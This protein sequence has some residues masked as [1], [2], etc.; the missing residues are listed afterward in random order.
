MSQNAWSS[1]SGWALV[2]LLMFATL[3]CSPAHGQS[4]DRSSESKQDNAPSALAQ[5]VRPKLEAALRSVADG[6]D[7]AAAKATI[8]QLFD[9]VA[10][11][12]GDDELELFRDAAAAVRLGNLLGFIDESERADFMGF[13]LDHMALARALVFL[14]RQDANEKR[15]AIEVIQRLRQKHA[16][17]MD[18]FANLAAAIAV[19]HDKPLT[20]RI[21]ENKTT[22]PDPVSLYEYYVGNADRMV[23]PV[24]NLPAELLVYVVDSTASIDEMRWALNKYRGTRNVGQ[25]FFTIEY[26]YDHFRKGDPKKVTQAGFN[27]PN[28][29]KYGGV[30][31]DQAYFA[32]AVG[33]AIGVP[34]TYT[35][36][37]SAEVSHAWVGFLESDKRAAWWNFNSGRYEAY[38]GVSGYVSDPQGGGRL[39]DSTVA[40]LA[41]YATAP[42]LDRYASIAMTDVVSRLLGVELGTNIPLQIAETEQKPLRGANKDD[43]LALLEAALRTCPGYADAWFVVR[44]Q[45]QRGALTLEEKKK[46]ATVLHRLCGERYPDFYLAVVAP[47]IETVDDVDEQNTLWNAAFRTFQR[48]FDLAASVR[49]RQATMW[50]NAGERNKAGMCCEDV[51]K[52]YA[53]AGPFVLDALKVATD[54][55]KEMN[56]QNRIPALYEK[57]WTLTKKPKDMAAEFST[58]SN[59][60]RVGLLYAETLTAVGRTADAGNVRSAIGAR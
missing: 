19:V 29:L 57:A 49:M 38:Q 39:P 28:I 40:L 44:K 9:E 15:G 41:A 12:A 23:F 59:W 2:A 8:S 13:M 31:A 60:Y 46:W 27:L 25:L 51:I 30:C 11:R 32:C 24:R 4:R 17:S 56:Q 20:R 6:G 42:E 22:A 3:L 58:Q 33:K 45:A 16:N 54:L 5:E 1:R 14:V 10:A 50:R 36:A 35:R 21:N 55:L 47:M 26:D 7:F 53:N 52:R 37:A 43:A 18:E 48:R 34:T